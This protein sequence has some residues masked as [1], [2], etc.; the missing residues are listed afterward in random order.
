MW[1]VSYTHLVAGAF[2]AHIASGGGP[3][4]QRQGVVATLEHHGVR[5]AGERSLVDDGR[6]ATGA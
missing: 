3:L 6:R 4:P 1:P 2:E 5:S